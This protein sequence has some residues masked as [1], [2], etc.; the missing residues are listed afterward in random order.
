V[1]GY[2]IARAEVKLPNTLRL[3]RLKAPQ[4]GWLWWAR[5]DGLFFG[6]TVV[7]CPQRNG[8]YLYIVGV[9]EQGGRKVG[10]L[11]RVP[12]DRIADLGS[13]E[14][15]AGEIPPVHWSRSPADAADVEGLTDFPSELS[16]AYHPYLGGYLAVHSVGIEPR[17]RLSLALHPWGPYRQ[18]AEIGA[19]HQ[20]FAKSFCYAGKEHPELAEENGRILYI[21]YV[22]QQR[23]W[24]QLLKVILSRSI[25]Q[26]LTGLSRSHARPHRSRRVPQAL[27]HTSIV[28]AGSLMAGREPPP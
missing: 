9:A 11:A 22:D 10:K 23:Y 25:S 24:L 3:T 13:Y 18:I 7:F 21:T 28:L 16:V 26:E 27:R 20:A 17:I 12:K 5:K 15:F 14:Y 6:V 4:G 1:E 8:E 19:P 2:G